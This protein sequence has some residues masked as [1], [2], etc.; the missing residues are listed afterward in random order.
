MS[1]IPERHD[2]EATH[3][4]PEPFEATTLRASLTVSDLRRSLGWYRDVVGFTVTREYERDGDLMAVALRAGAVELLL[5]RDDGAKGA[6][7]AKGEGF[8]LQLVTRQDVDALARG[9]RER[10]GTLAA[11]PTDAYGARV[12]RL[13]DPDG[14][15]LVISSP[16]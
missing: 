3:P 9:I 5:T 7:R 2:L 14:F 1:E 12:F 13:R 8:S 10:G 6:D 16:Q 11:E 15:R 4:A